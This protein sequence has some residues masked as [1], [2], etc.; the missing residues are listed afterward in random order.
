[1]RIYLNWC[2]KIYVLKSRI[3]FLSVDVPKSSELLEN[4]RTT[5]L[6]V[7]VECLMADD[8]KLVFEN[9]YESSTNNLTPI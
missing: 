7:S 2:H 5:E 6:I 9:M 4:I 1:M 8:S 3:F